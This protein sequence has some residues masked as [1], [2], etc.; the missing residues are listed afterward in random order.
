[1]LLLASRV[2]PQAGNVGIGTSSPS[3]KLHV[4]NTA[5]AD[6]ALLESTQAFSTLAFKSSTNSSTVTVGIDGAGNAAFENRTI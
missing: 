6:V 2:L 4:Y 5:S 1:M 3:K